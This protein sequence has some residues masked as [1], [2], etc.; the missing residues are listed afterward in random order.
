MD[1]ENIIFENISKNIPRVAS[2]LNIP[3]IT[4]NKLKSQMYPI[5]SNIIVFI[6]M[7]I[8]VI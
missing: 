1:F 4:P 2:S 8:G 5:I 7:I 3:K 6:L